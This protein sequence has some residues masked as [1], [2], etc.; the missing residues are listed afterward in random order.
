MR[1]TKHL[2]LLTLLVSALTS[3]SSHEQNEQPRLDSAGESYTINEN[4]EDL[5]FSSSELSY[6][7]SY[8][9]G[10]ATVED[11]KIKISATT[12]YF[13]G[14]RSIYKTKIDF[15]DEVYLNF[16]D[17]ESANDNVSLMIKMV[18]HNYS[19][20]DSAYITSNDFIGLN[21]DFSLN[22]KNALL[23]YHGSVSNMELFNDDELAFKNKKVDVSFYIAA[24]NNTNSGLANESAWIK[25]SSFNVSYKKSKDA[26]EF[27][28]FN[29]SNDGVNVDN[30]PSSNVLAK[31]KNDADFVIKPTLNSIEVYSDKLIFASSEPSKV[32]VTKDGNVSF[33]GVTRDTARVVAYPR[34]D[35][36]IGGIFDYSS[37]NMSKNS[38]FYV[39]VAGL[40]QG[41]A[42]YSNVLNLF[43]TSNT[44]PLDDNLLDLFEGNLLEVQKISV[45][46]IISSINLVVSSSVLNILNNYQ[47][48]AEEKAE[49]DSNEKS[50]SIKFALNNNSYSAT[51]EGKVSVIKCSADLL[52]IVAKEHSYAVGDNFSIKEKY[53]NS[54][55]SRNTNSDRYLV[56]W[57]NGSTFKYAYFSTNVIDS[58]E[59][60]KL[61]PSDIAK[62]INTD[63]S[64]DGFSTEIVNQDGTDVYR[65]KLKLGDLT[66][67]YAAPFLEL[68]ADIYSKNEKEYIK[69]DFTRKV[70][71]IIDFGDCV[72]L[73]YNL[74][75]YRIAGRYLDEYWRDEGANYTDLLAGNT[76]MYIDLEHYA[77]KGNNP[78]MINLTITK[79]LPVEFGF[80]IALR[81][82]TEVGYEGHL[83]IKNIYI[84]YE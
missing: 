69:I 24:F 15:T 67:Y 33:I 32:S 41:N 37:S 4:F 18:F 79:S 42:I 19:K 22:I 46:N 52:T 58:K 35:I 78:S 62:S 66:A 70:K 73:S 30:V 31:T 84:L 17:F 27:G 3:C 82:R 53:L 44:S 51:N 49:A 74:R 20:T 28:S 59:L 1:N 76:F 57:S 13:G 48:T 45:D 26:L 50:Y 77:K 63:R 71:M 6:W 7:L 12:E 38:G 23:R 2:L 16:K 40:W 47:N 61:A 72:N 21:G 75:F 14:I 5:D 39:S 43:A 81:N 54:D 8:N 65:M 25:F 9:K 68:Y 29:I 34:E 10:Q 64:W 60:I 80:D 11:N 83:D 36:A 56:L 55:Y